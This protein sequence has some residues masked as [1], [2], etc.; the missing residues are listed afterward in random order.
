MLEM[1]CKHERSHAAG[2]SKHYKVCCRLHTGLNQLKSS[3]TAPKRWQPLKVVTNESN[4]A[5]FNYQL[6]G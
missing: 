4:R 6:S 3:L 1:N 2:K 5:E